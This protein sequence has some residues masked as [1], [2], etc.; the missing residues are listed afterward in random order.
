MDVCQCGPFAS[1]VPHWV[2]DVVH[3]EL[4]PLLSLFARFDSKRADI[5][6]MFLKSLPLVV[7]PLVNEEADPGWAFFI[8]RWATEMKDVFS[9]M[10]RS[11]HERVPPWLLDG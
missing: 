11:G 3:S 7:Y 5:S 2:V 4:L 8:S 6:C 1:A 10:V 9:W